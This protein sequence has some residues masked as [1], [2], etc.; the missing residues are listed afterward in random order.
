MLQDCT[1]QHAEKS[2]CGLRSMQ[3]GSEITASISISIVKVR[4]VGP[5]FK[6]A[7]NSTGA[8]V[9]LFRLVYT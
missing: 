1:K 6:S 9:D 2:S 3:E 8:K 4:R 5:S 7:R